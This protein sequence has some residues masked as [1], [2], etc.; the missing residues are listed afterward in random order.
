MLLLSLP[1]EFASIP[2]CMARQVYSHFE[3]KESYVIVFRAFCQGPIEIPVF[4][5]FIFMTLILN[6]KPD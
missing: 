4:H 5:R 3:Y 1:S 2:P 6:V